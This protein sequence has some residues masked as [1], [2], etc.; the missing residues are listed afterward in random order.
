MSRMYGLEAK[1]DLEAH[2]SAKTFWM[3]TAVSS[4]LMVLA[5][6]LE[7]MCRLRG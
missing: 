5:L 3:L 4:W 1:H 7:F 6:R 2:T